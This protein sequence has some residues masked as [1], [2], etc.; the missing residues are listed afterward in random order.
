MDNLPNNVTNITFGKQF[1]QSVYHLPNSVTSITFRNKSRKPLNKLP[2]SVK[3][4]CFDNIKKTHVYNSVNIYIKNFIH[5]ATDHKTL[6]NHGFSLLSIK[7]L[8]TKKIPYGCTHTTKK[9]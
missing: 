1:D 9:N 7:S 6:F 3:T 5:K 8:N 4:I 2:K